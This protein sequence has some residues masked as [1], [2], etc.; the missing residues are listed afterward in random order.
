MQFTKTITLFCIIKEVL[1]FV[2]FHTCILSR[3]KHKNNKG[4]QF[5]IS[6]I[7]I[8]LLR[9][10]QCIRTITLFCIINE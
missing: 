6:S 5:E 4:Y 2:I 3:A 7:D 9:E 8:S 10:V 1:P